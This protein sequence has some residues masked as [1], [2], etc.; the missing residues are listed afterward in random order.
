MK[1]NKIPV[2][3]FMTCVFIACGCRKSE[4]NIAFIRLYPNILYDTI[5]NPYLYL[6]Q[7]A[8]YKFSNKDS[9]FIGVSENY[10]NIDKEKN[11]AIWLR[12]IL[13]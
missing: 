2:L 3:L 12:K 7:Y 9:L 11:F 6:K 5:G 8:E 10:Y 13:C 1:Q 4:D